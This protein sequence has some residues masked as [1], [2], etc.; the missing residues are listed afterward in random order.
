VQLRW[1]RKKEDPL[2][3]AIF[4]RCSQLVENGIAR[5]SRRESDHGRLSQLIPK[6]GLPNKTTLLVP[7][8]ENECLGLIEDCA[9]LLWIA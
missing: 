3:P 8:F 1:I 4:G 6:N 5:S 7:E 2:S 9:I